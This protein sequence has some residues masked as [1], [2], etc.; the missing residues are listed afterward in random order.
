MY[1]IIGI[2]LYIVLRYSFGRVKLTKKYLKLNVRLDEELGKELIE[3]AKIAG[4]NKS[5]LARICIHKQLTI[6]KNTK[7]IKLSLLE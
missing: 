4:V 3:M 2:L 5:V 7:E 1:A 6:F